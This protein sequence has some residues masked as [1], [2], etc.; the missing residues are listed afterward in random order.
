MC[1]FK[2]GRWPWPLAVKI[3]LSSRLFILMQETPEH[4]DKESR[5]LPIAREDEDLDEDLDFEV[6]SM[7]D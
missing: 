3:G 2:S 1:I 5:L 7:N 4:D 6:E